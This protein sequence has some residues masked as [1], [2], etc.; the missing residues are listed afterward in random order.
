MD[1]DNMPQNIGNDI[2]AEI[3]DG[4]ATVA[5]VA[6]HPAIQPDSIHLVDDM[7]TLGQLGE[8]GP[9]LRVSKKRNVFNVAV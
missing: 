9:V 4:G 1:Q 2:D 8:G 7:L 6:E 3:V 5:A